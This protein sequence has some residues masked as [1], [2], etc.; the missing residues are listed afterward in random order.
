MHCGR[1]T[2]VG[3]L[4]DLGLG[5]LQVD[6][7]VRAID[8]AVASALRRHVGKPV[9]AAESAAMAVILDANPHRVFV[10]RAGRVE[11][12]QPIPPPNGKSPQGRHTHVLPNPP[13]TW[14]DASRNGAITE[15]LSAVRPRP[16]QYVTAKAAAVRCRTRCTQ[17]AP[18]QRR[19]GGRRAVRY[20]AER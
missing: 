13:C 2:K 6:A 10:S 11:V 5:L 18:H 19:S 1:R 20:R 3:F 14:P 16:I 15:R 17:E 4:F 12:F 9:F 7:F 8:S